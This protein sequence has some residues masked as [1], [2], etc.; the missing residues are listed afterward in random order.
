MTCFIRL[1]NEPK[2]TKNPILSEDEARKFF[3]DDSIPGETL[4]EENLRIRV[5]SLSPD[6]LPLVLGF[7]FDIPELTNFAPGQNAYVG[8]HN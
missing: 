8:G 6:I 4:G 2:A 1:R 5:I 7:E 3:A